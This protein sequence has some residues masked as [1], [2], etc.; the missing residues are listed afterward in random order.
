MSAEDD[1]VEERLG[2]MMNTLL[3]AIQKRETNALGLREG[4]VNALLELPGQVRDLTAIATEARDTA[5]Q[6]KKILVG[7][8]EVG[9]VAEVAALKQRG[10]DNR[11]LPTTVDRRQSIPPCLY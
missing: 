8:G 3:A 9:L 1:R 5:A 2:G 6:T 7:N 4:E 10:K 11:D